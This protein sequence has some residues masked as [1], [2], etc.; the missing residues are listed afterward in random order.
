[1]YV[2][3]RENFI[4]E[5]RPSLRLGSLVFH[6]PRFGILSFHGKGETEGEREGRKRNRSASERFLVVGVKRFLDGWRRLI[7]LSVLRER[8]KEIFDKF[9]RISEMGF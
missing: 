2:T 6:R 5:A 1:M 3:R 4:S 9:G 8:V 7:F